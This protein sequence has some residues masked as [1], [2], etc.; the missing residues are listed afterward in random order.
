[1]ASPQNPGAAVEVGTIS[2]IPAE[3]VR[4]RARVEGGGWVEDTWRRQGSGSLA[5]WPGPGAT[6]VF[7]NFVPAPPPAPRGSRILWVAARGEARGP[8]QSPLLSAQSQPRWLSARTSCCSRSADTADPIPRYRYPDTDP[9]APAQA[10][11]SAP[12]RPPCPPP[13]CSAAAPRPLSPYPAD[14]IRLL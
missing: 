1:M 3:P 10:S 12:P 2:A 5:W 4:G 9:R 11:L 8:P 13:L 7:G 6:L 14:G